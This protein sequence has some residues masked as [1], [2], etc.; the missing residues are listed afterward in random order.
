MMESLHWRLI[1]KKI[2]SMFANQHVRAICSRYW[3]IRYVALFNFA[4]NRSRIIGLFNVC[5][6][7]FYG[8]TSGHTT[9]YTEHILI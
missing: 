2:F 7:T 5:V 6:A 1:S 3:A 9:L 8:L 4:K